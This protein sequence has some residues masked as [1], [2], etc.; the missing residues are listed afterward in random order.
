[1]YQLMWQ[2]ML[3]TQFGVDLES[4]TL[5]VSVFMFGLGLG[6]LWGGMLADKWLTKLLRL[7]VLIEVGIALFGFASP[8]LIDYIGVVFFSS[9]KWVT[10]FVCFFILA[11]PTILMGATFPILVTHV[12]RFV[13]N[14]G[15]SV[16]GLYCANTLGGA[17]GAFCAGF[18]LLTYYDLAQVIYGA[19]IINL[20]IAATA[21]VFYSRQIT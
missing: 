6:G 8:D 12:N 15:Q 16:G 1:M 13:H 7:Y 17:A 10:A 14:I 21:Y 3:F 11:V 4:V 5:I 20:L 19:A 18:V 9:H 2:R